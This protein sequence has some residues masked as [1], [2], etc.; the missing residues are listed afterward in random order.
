MYQLSIDGVKSGPYQEKDLLE[1]RNSGQLPASAL[2]WREGWAEWRPAA[3]VIASLQPSIPP[4]AAAADTPKAEAPPQHEPEITSSLAIGA[5]IAG[6]SVF[7]VFPL[8]VAAM[9]TAEVLGHLPRMRTVWTIFPVFLI[10]AAAAVVLGHRARTHIRK[11]GARGDR[12]ATAGLVMGYL[13]LMGVPATGLLAL[14]VLPV[15]AHKHDNFVQEQVRDNLMLIWSAADQY[16]LSS[17][18]Q[19][20]GYRQLID[21]GSYLENLAPA[22]GESYEELVVHR[23]DQ[24]VSVT[25][26][27]GHTVIYRSEASAGETDSGQDNGELGD[28]SNSPENG[29]AEIAPDA[30][31]QMPAQS[32]TQGGV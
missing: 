28:E 27:D 11:T 9:G 8:C 22:A 12:L 21:A 25:T 23:G 4:A 14:I 17:E 18:A 32:P 3:E 5:L 15:L 6:L 24:V 26:G 13:G 1:M 20:V 30:E 16:F 19:E 10:V 7:V 29:A 31:P 2:C